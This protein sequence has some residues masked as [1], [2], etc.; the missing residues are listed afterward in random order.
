MYF[1]QV[2]S[3][4]YLIFTKKNFLLLVY[5]L[6]FRSQEQKRNMQVE[7][8]NFLCDQVQVGMGL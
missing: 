8:K 4:L 5:F 3:F 1:L 6:Q 7:V 2:H